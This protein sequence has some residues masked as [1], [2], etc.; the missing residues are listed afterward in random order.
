MSVGWGSRHGRPGRLLPQHTDPARILEK[1][2]VMSR[3][4]GC[5]GS[6]DGIH[7]GRV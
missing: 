1:A 2:G 6:G 7:T 4:Q 3:R 5:E